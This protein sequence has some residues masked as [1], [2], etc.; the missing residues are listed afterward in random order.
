VPLT[1]LSEG[2]GDE[3]V[4]RHPAFDDLP[5]HA[6]T[7]DVRL[8]GLY[9]PTIVIKVSTVERWMGGGVVMWYSI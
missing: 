4:I 9:P 5:C 8:S 7:V 6:I 3:F 2:G 1:L